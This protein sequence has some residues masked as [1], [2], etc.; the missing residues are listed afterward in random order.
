MAGDYLVAFG[1]MGPDGRLK[2]SIYS[3]KNNVWFDKDLPQPEGAEFPAIVP[4]GNTFLTIGG[5]V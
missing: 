2:T 5:F 3:L 1:G 4:F